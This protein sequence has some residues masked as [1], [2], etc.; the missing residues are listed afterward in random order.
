M[1]MKDVSDDELEL[2]KSNVRK[3]VKN[4]KH[5]ITDDQMIAMVDKIKKGENPYNSLTQM[6]EPEVQKMTVPDFQKQVTNANY[7]KIDGL[8][9]MGKFYTSNSEILGRPLKVLEVKKISSI[10]EENGDFILNDIVRR[11][12][13]G[14]D[15]NELYVAD[16]LYII[17]WLRA[18]SYRES[19]Y[20]VPFVCPKCNKKTDYHF[21]INNLEVQTI[22]ND[23]DPEKLIK[24]G[25]YMISYDYLRIKDEL[26]IDRFKELNSQAVGEIDGELLAV[27]Q[28]IKAIDG[29][30]LT[31]LQKYQWMIELT[32]GEFAYLKTY[33][34]K[35]GMGIKPFV[36]VE[37]KE[38]GGTA[39]VGITFQD[40][41]LI[42]EFKFE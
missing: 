39:P 30:A 6:I 15:I 17:F 32:P 18:N 33:I 26:Y 5:S 35:K 9:S 19:G 20:V 28:M 29:Q 10:N 12:T 14:I 16:K 24:I 22:S 40:S 7:W 8:P 36:M 2:V 27:A 3:D 4:D 42:P 34:E 13:T 31:L 38:C 41:F 23:F 37:C 21:E 25:K 11:T 1:Q